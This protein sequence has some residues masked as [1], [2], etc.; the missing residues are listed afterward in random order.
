MARQIIP[1][2]RGSIEDTPALRKQIEGQLEQLKLATA[3]EDVP[4]WLHLLGSLGE[5]YY[6]LGDYQDAFLFLGK[7]LALARRV[8]D[9][10]REAVNQIRL[11]TAHQY[12]G[13]HLEAEARFHQ[14]LDFVTA[15]HQTEYLDFIWQHLG[16][17]LVEQGR[18][19][20]AIRCF[21]E[22]LAYR[23]VKGDA[24]LI[25]STERAL[26]A[27]RQDAHGKRESNG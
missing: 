19:E 9:R 11:A 13:N 10:R 16:K 17:C 5:T 26:S 15:S 1:F 12:A 8:G 23:R 21:E 25:A 24:D 3:H 7:A 20:E 18:I 2:Q 4:T 22:A 14:A 6:L 27:I